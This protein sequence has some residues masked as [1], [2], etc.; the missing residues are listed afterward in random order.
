MSA[1]IQW[2]GRS[3]SRAMWCCGPLY[4]N[5]RRAT[6]GFPRIYATKINSQQSQIWNSKTVRQ[7]ARQPE[8]ARTYRRGQ[9]YHTA[10][11]RLMPPPSPSPFFP[12]LVVPPPPPTRSSHGTAPP[13]LMTTMINR[14]A[15]SPRAPLDAETK[16][17][18]G[19]PRHATATNCRY[20][21]GA[22]MPVRAARPRNQSNLAFKIESK[23]ESHQ[24]KI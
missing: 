13:S 5:F 22:L 8:A 16:A 7:I 19:L 4:G 1:L 14:P 3:F 11:S 23:P 21:S 9:W 2:R 24:I 15:L 6:R 17:T 12:P 18:R 10:T 20:L